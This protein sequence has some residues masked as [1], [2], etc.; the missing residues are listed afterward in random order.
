MPRR[1]KFKEQRDGLSPDGVIQKCET[2]GRGDSNSW[3]IAVEQLG[4]SLAYKSIAYSH[5][6]PPIEPLIR[7][8]TAKGNSVTLGA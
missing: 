1:F 7:T 3:N 2:E 5:S 6:G 8:S 4:T